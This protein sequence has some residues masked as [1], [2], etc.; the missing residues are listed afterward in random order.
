MNPAESLQKYYK[1]KGRA[2]TLPYVEVTKEEFIR[3]LVAQGETQAKA[4]QSATIAEGLGS[5]IE[6]G[7]EMVGIKKCSE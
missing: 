4:E 3:R 6:I 1:A 2:A 7:E 5:H